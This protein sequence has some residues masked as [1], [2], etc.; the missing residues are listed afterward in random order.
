MREQAL[1]NTFDTTLMLQQ[2]MRKLF[3][4]WERGREPGE[5][6]PPS[7]DEGNSDTD[8]EGWDTDSS[9]EDW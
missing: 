8:D 3:R 7:G 6:D 1:R 4:Q 5:T 2:Y 9:R